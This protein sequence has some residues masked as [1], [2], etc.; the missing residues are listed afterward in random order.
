MNTFFFYKRHKMKPL[1]IPGMQPAHT[2]VTSPFCFTSKQMPPVIFASKLT[3][4][5]DKAWENTKDYFII[6]MRC[7][8]SLTEWCFI[9][10]SQRET[11]AEIMCRGAGTVTWGGRVRE[12]V[13]RMRKISLYCDMLIVVVYVLVLF[14]LVHDCVCGSAC[15]LCVLRWRL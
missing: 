4:D 12:N 10:Q 8:W 11:V 14:F 15:L 6:F 13:M 3:S 9:Q 5:S 1:W 7:S 2:Q